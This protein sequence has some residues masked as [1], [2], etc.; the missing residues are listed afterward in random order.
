MT[1]SSKCVVITCNDVYVQYAIPALLRFTFKNRDFD[2]FVLGTHFTESSKRQL[3]HYGVY[4]R[5]IDLRED[6]PNLDLRPY[7]RNYPI[8][9]FYHFAAYKYLGDFE[10]LVTIEC[11]V[12]ANK[13]LDVDFGTID[14]IA[15]AVDDERIRD[16]T[17]VM[18]DIVR[19][20]AEFPT[21]STD[22]FRCRSGV[23]IYNVSGLNYIRFY[24]AIVKLY[25]SSWDIGA[26]RCGDDSLFV[27]YQMLN[28]QFIKLLHRSYNYIGGECEDPDTIHLYHESTAVKWWMGTKCKSALG[29]HFQRAFRSYIRDIDYSF[30]LST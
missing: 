18:S 24:E 10:H 22:G 19:L 13:A 5:E 7:G 8:E 4:W 12:F 2:M 16:F 3:E 29:L 14:Y 27:L 15:A 21:I 25:K 26:P 30:Q 20:R 28:G 23:R 6:F 17:P 1:T 11:D 9:C